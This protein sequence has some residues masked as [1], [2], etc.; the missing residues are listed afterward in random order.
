MAN[1]GPDVNAFCYA[2]EILDDIEASLSR[3]R[4]RTYLDATGGNREEAIRLHVWNTAISGAFYGPLQVLEIALRNAMSRRLG[5]RYGDAWYDS[6]RAG[7]DNGA[8]ERVQSARNVVA[9][10]GYGDDPHRIVATL[11]FGFWVALLGPGGRSAGSRKANYEMTLWRPALR[12]AFAHCDTLARK[13]AHRPLYQLRTLRNRIAHHEPIFARNLVA[14]HKRIL[15]V[16]GWVSPAT[17]TWIEHHSRV[18]DAL[19]T[20]KVADDIRF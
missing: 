16:A 20:E 9:R 2:E 3:E 12:R 11:S 1:G 8:L 13:Q 6:G 18:L 19:G 5:E 17:R 7:L 14:D 4:L 10:D 15:D